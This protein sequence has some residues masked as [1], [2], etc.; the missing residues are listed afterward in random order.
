MNGRIVEIIG[1]FA[2]ASYTKL[3]K[4]FKYISNSL[5]F[6]IQSEPNNKRKQFLKNPSEIVSISLGGS[7]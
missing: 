5:G 7:F 6:F 1:N 4:Y 2:V 3:K